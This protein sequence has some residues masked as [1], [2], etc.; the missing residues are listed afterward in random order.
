MRPANY[1]RYIIVLRARIRLVPSSFDV[2]LFRLAI[3]PPLFSYTRTPLPPS[4]VVSFPAV[5][6]PASHCLLSFRR[7]QAKRNDDGRA[8]TETHYTSV[9]F[10]QRKCVV[11][12]ARI[13]AQPAPGKATQKK[14]EGAWN[15]SWLRVLLV[16]SI[17]AGVHTCLFM[18]LRY[19]CQYLC[20]SWYL[21][22]TLFHSLSFHRSLAV[23]LLVPPDDCQ[24][25]ISLVS[26]KIDIG[27]FFGQNI[28]GILYFHNSELV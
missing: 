21:I 9:Y 2:H 22:G 20:S 11:V 19:V 15:A 17:V 5:R 7:V 4:P 25:I 8:C 1:R 10:Y 12:R 24:L 3:S 26:S 27:Y 23:T 28:R 13:P 14:K 6:P 18:Q 16:P